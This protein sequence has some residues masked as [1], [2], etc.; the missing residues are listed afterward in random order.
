MTSRRLTLK[1]LPEEE[2]PREKLAHLGE[3]ALSDAEL[4]AII[5][6]SGTRAESAVQMAQRILR[7]A[8]DLKTLATLSLAELRGFNGIGSARASQLKAA[9][10]IAR[11]WKE[12]RAEEPERFSHSRSV[13]L[14][15]KDYF[16]G[17]QQEEFWV[18]VLDSK[19]KLLNKTP[20]SRGTLNASIVHPR[21]VFYAAIKNLGAGIIVLHNHPSGEP[22]PSREDHQV[23]HQLREAGKVI[24]IQL[25][26]HIIIGR[27]TFFS[28]KDAGL[29]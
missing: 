6:G 13:Y 23:T 8:G 25:L 12:S 14:H 22:E 19:N 11:R 26:D 15:F 4:L 16:C 18:V 27:S 29:L 1:N 3:D 10:E 28:F 9:L 21:E 20:V 24:G 2:R 5:M 7:D 17:K